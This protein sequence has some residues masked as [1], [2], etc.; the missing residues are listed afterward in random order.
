MV[1]NPTS[2]CPAIRPSTRG[3]PRSADGR[4][5]TPVGRIVDGVHEQLHFW[6]GGDSIGN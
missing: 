6:G 4:I 5:H 3:L 2:Q 1:D